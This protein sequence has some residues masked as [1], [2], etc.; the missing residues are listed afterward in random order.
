MNLENMIT[1]LLEQSEKP[2]KK[3]EIE[4]RLNILLSEKEMKEL[5]DNCIIVRTKSGRICLPEYLGLIKGIFSAN[6]RGYGFVK[7]S[8]EDIFIPP[9]K[10]GGAMDGDTV[11]VQ[12]T[13]FASSGKNAEGCIVKIINSG[14]INIVGTVDRAKS[15]VFVVPDNKG[16]NDVFIPKGLSMNAKSGHKV[17]V[18]IIKREEEGMRAEGRI[19]EILGYSGD[20]GVDILSVIRQY[21]IPYEFE[22]EV[23]RNAQNSAS[24]KLNTSG[25]KD[26][27]SLNVFTIDGDDAKDLD[28]AVSV[29]KTDKGYRLGVHIADVSHYVQEGTALD[30]SAQER[31][32]SVYLINK[33]VPMLPE[34]LSNGAC[35]LNEGEIKLTLSCTMEFDTAGSLISSDISKSF[36]K[37]KHRMTYSNV[38]KILGGDKKL[39]KEYSDIYEDILK[40]KELSDILSS[41]RKAKGSIDLDI[42]EAKIDVDEKGKPIRVYVRQRGEAERIIEEFMLA[43][44]KAVAEEYFFREMPFIYRVH[45]KMDEEKALEI[46]TLMQ[47][48]GYKARRKQNG[49][50]TK[51]IQ[52]ILKAC[53]GQDFESIIS[54]IVLRSMKKA[55]YMNECKGHFGLGFEYYCHFTSPIRRYPDLYIHRIISKT[56]NGEE[57]PKSENENAFVL[58]DI[59]SK[60]ERRAMEAERELESL[61]KAEFME[62]KIGNIYPAMISGVAQTAIFAEL[63]N[64][65][66]GVIPL[67][68]INDDY[69]NYNEKQFCVIGETTGKRI[70]LGDKVKIMVKAADKAARRVE[71]ELVNE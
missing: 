13:K 55:V 6:M 35:S 41:N 15:T 17:V 36:I 62:D 19:V 44:N 65:V 20:F 53:E 45:E 27:T 7:G 70:S 69:Y 1:E 24:Q 63:D 5:L 8:D 16:I 48:Y 47:N 56:L 39:I 30:K 66:E 40:A 49:I 31:A 42:D 58:S 22:E 38:N 18:E 11:L 59:S 50:S 54:R 32:T 52:N 43:A 26:F 9:G 21:G 37:S 3:R 71:F 67:S 28:D 12:I 33:V 57:M 51:D 61:K 14:S 29:E 60:A 64:T 4:E 2:L 68:S 25:R 23:V 46:S 34:A 10:K